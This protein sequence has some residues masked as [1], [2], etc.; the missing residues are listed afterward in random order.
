[1][2]D[3]ESIPAQPD[4][5]RPVINMPFKSVLCAR[6][7]EPLR[8]KWP[9]G[10]VPFA[11]EALRDVA[12]QPEIAEACEGRHEA[13][14][15]LLAEKPLCCRLTPERLVQVYI[16]AGFGKRGVCWICRS[17]AVGAA[18]RHYNRFKRL[19]RIGHVCFTCIVN[20]IREVKPEEEEC[21]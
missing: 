2:S 4:S 6:H 10:Y 1:M 13:L 14:A 12:A 21:G 15:A 9:Q 19:N 18:F 20:E 11:I 16:A 17:L 5:P 8:E 3:Q 7:G